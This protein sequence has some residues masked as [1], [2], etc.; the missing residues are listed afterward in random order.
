MMLRNSFSKTIRQEFLAS[1]ERGIDART[2]VIQL[3][4]EYGVTPEDRMT[5]LQF[6]LSLAVTAWQIGRLYPNLREEALDLIASDRTMNF[7][8]NKRAEERRDE[9]LQI[10]NIL[11]Q[12]QT[13]PISLK[14]QTPESLL[15]LLMSKFGA[16]PNH[17]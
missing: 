17:V 11:S 8:P 10:A 6:V 14:E 9:L 4:K 7:I 5:R 13:R 2:A 15:S 3:T 1:L 16:N 12:P